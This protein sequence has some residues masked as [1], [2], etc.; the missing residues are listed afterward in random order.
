VRLGK[1]QLHLLKAVGITAALVVPSPASR[2][3]CE[4]GLLKAHGADGS[5]AAI[6]PAGLR[7]LADAADAGRV[8][9]F[10]M[11]DSTPSLLQEQNANGGK[12]IAPVDDAGGKRG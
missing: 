7:A 12:E 8:A 10:T 2:R 9:L 3:L 5:F 6:T 4:M 1:Q 11:P